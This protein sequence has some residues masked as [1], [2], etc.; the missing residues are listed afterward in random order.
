MKEAW[1]D[2]W[3]WAPWDWAGGAKNCSAAGYGSTGTETGSDWAETGGLAAV[4]WVGQGGR[5]QTG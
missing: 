1:G 2:E 5:I 4:V 3:Q